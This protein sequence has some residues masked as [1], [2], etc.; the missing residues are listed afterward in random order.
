[1][2][3]YVRV[4]NGGRSDVIRIQDA[5]TFEEAQRVIRQQPGGELASLQDIGTTAG[6]SA[7]LQASGGR[8]VSGHWTWDGYSPTSYVQYFLGMGGPGGGGYAGGGGTGD[9][10]DTGPTPP[11]GGGGGTGSLPTGD[12]LQQLLAGLEGR[13]NVFAQE[14]TDPLSRAGGTTFLRRGLEAA[15]PSVEAAFQLRNLLAPTQ[16][17][18]VDPSALIEF[19][20]F[21]P[22]LSAGGSGFQRPSLAGLRQSVIDL[23]SRNTAGTLSETAS[24][25]LEDPKL[26][27]R[28]ISATSRAREVPGFMR[29]AFDR[30]FARRF[31]NASMADPEGRLLPGFVERG[32]R[33]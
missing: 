6:N 8:L 11:G 1:M 9:T 26:Q 4:I 18:V 23:M 16:G 17:G 5:R 24:E 22:T 28:L 19:N 25:R 2:A 3:Y 29:D 30:V 27:A 12:A 33:F 13:Q 32:F 20:D 21:L 14:V 31:R 15:G 7:A 10:G